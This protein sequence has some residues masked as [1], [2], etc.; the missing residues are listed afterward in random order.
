MEKLTYQLPQ[1]LFV[2]KLQEMKRSQ[3]LVLADTEGSLHQQP[4]TEAK[5]IKT[6]NYAKLENKMARI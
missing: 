5:L 6:Q 4:V 2:N 3:D 1:K